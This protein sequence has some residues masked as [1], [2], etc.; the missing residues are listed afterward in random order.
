MKRR[1]LVAQLAVAALITACGGSLSVTQTPSSS[2]TPTT[3][4]NPTRSPS[5]T[6]VVHAGPD[7]AADGGTASLPLPLDA[8]HEWAAV[9]EYGDQIILWASPGKSAVA[10]TEAPQ[11][12]LWDPATGSIE[13]AWTGVPG[14]Q[15]VYAGSDGDW[16]ATVRSNFTSYG[17]GQLIL[18]DLKTGE[19]RELTD[20]N[21]GVSAYGDAA[22]SN[23]EVVWTQEVLGADAAVTETVHLYA[24][25]TATTT[26]LALNDQG[27][28]KIWSTAIGGSKVEWLY[29]DGSG[30]QMF[31]VVHDLASGLETKTGLTSG[32][33]SASISRDGRYV[34]WDDGSFDKHVI[35]LSSGQQID[36]A[37]A[38]GWGVYVTDRYFSWDPVPVEGMP[39]DPAGFFDLQSNELRRLPVSNNVFTATGHVMGHWFVW[40][41]VPI[42]N[43]V[44][45]RDLGHWY[46]LQ[47]SD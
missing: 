42:V 37:H 10:E 31:V 45:Q 19:V 5:P 18:R 7:I 2:A 35:D 15:D 40:M 12:S 6:P 16:L 36:V 3:T 11:Y 25:A 1:V 30:L 32:V 44:E 47:L 14:M 38:Q 41:S 33:H 8:N 27:D 22:V 28:E 20:P 43:G 24:I 17:I 29:N 21:S 26:T 34:V 4:Q 46:A 39:G 23:G 13:P 9:G